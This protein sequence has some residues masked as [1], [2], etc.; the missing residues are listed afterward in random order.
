LIG[1]LRT[2]FDSI[3][4][5]AVDG[6]GVLFTRIRET[7]NA[8]CYRLW[9]GQALFGATPGEAFFCKCDR[10]NNPDLDLENGIVRLDVYVAPVPTMERLLINVVRTA[11]GQVQITAQELS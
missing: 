5:S 10:G 7:A 3:V 1:T 11:I 6:Q 4:F 2:A 9:A 8:I